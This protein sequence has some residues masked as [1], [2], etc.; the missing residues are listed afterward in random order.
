MIFRKN[1]IHKN[2]IIVMAKTPVPDQVKTRLTPPL[3]PEIASSLYLNFLLDKIEQVKN[4]EAQAF[5]AFTPATG[6]TFFRSIIPSGFILI[7]QVGRNLGERLINVSKNL[8]VQGFKKVLILDSDSPNL[9]PE[10]ILK[11]FTDLDDCDIVLGPCEDGGYYLIGL[12]ASQPQLFWDIPWSTSGVTE[13]TLQKAQSLGLTVSLL[14]TW[15]DIDTIDDLLRLKSDLDSYTSDK[16][17]IFFCENTYREICRM[18]K[19]N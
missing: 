14:E 19:S 8:F 17:G 10:Y 11:G 13:L 12:K 7:D 6:L 16:K 4:I 1:A 15:Y 3:P 2:A 18:E 5:I 9:P